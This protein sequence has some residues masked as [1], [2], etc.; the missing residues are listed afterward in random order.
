MTKLKK[1]LTVDIQR[2][3]IWDC[4]AIAE[5]WGKMMKEVTPQELNLPADG[6]ETER[7]LKSLTAGID[8]QT[9]SIF[10]A[11]SN[12]RIIGFIQSYIYVWKF[13]PHLACFTDSLYV[14]DKFRH[15]GIGEALIQTMKTDTATKGAIVWDFT[16]VRPK[17]WEKKGYK[18]IMTV[19]RQM[20]GGAGNVKK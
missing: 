20:K 12:F 11:K 18:T 14:L 19:H 16:S 1:D 10:V 17:V 13:T 2:A 7:F 9:N 8:L 15:K 6:K 4:P 5:L 3:T